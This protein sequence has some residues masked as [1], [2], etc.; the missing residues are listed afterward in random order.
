[1]RSLALGGAFD[2]ASPITSGRDSRP[3]EVLDIPE[4]TAAPLAVALGLVVFFLGLLIQAS[5]VGVIGVV[6]AIV[7]LLRWVWRTDVDA[8]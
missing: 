4:D 7:A 1:V 6:L 3:A 5:I 2:R 8:G